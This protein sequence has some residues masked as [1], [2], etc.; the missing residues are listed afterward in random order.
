M[1]GKFYQSTFT[2]SMAG[3]GL[4][5]FAVWGYIIAHTVNSTVEI[6]PTVVAALIGC[7]KENIEKALQYLEMTDPNSRTKEYEG[8]RI[9]KEGQFQY[10]V[11][12][13]E[14]YKNIR[15]NDERREYNRLKKREERERKRNEVNGDK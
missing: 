9:V 5:V 8:R 3:A 2:G 7:P 1:Y 15:N 13:H 4:E 10:F 11:P 14:K 12:N 6:N